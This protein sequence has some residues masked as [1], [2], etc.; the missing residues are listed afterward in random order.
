MKN[1]CTST[2][3]VSSDHIG[4]PFR[5]LLE[6][7]GSLLGRLFPLVGPSL[8]LLGHMGRPGK[9]LEASGEF[10]RAFWGSLG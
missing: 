9:V 10:I 5:T 1:Q 6:P 8:A 7:F 2:I 3:L 4:T